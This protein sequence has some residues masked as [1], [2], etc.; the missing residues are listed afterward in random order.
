[1]VKLCLAPGVVIANGSCYNN[2]NNNNDSYIVVI[3]AKE[4]FVQSAVVGG[5]DY[6]FHVSRLA[7]LGATPNP[8]EA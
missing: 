8:S 5:S 2:N 7:S 3:S 6:I 4:R 1:M